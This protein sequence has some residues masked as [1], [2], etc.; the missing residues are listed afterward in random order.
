MKTLFYLIKNLFINLIIQECLR[1]GFQPNIAY[2][3]SE[4]GF[5]SEMISENIGISICPKPIAKK[6]NQDLIKEISIDNAST[7]WNL[8]FISKNKTGFTC[9]S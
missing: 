2:E 7:P 9:S 6:V 5:I 4:W 1:A 8:G 3:I